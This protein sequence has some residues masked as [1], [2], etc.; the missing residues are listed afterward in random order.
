[1]KNGL[2]IRHQTC[3]IKNAFLFFLQFSHFHINVNFES[4]YAISKHHLCVKGICHYC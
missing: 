1:M 4:K 3:N 2:F